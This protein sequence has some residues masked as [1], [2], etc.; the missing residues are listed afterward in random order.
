MCR[1]LRLSFARLRTCTS[2]TFTSSSLETER[3]VCFRF[4]LRWRW[5][6]HVSCDAQVRHAIRHVLRLSFFSEVGPH[7]PRTPPAG[8]ETPLAPWRGRWVVPFATGAACRL[9]GGKGPG[10]RRLGKR[11]DRGGKTFVTKGG[12]RPS[13]R[14]KGQRENEMERETKGEGRQNH[15]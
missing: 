1:S 7:P 4:H 2:T 11:A 5:R 14:R 9:V 15:T 12:K 3:N 10:R 8:E 13:S 6:R